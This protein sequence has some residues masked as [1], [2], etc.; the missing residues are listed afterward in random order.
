MLL[1]WVP[2]PPLQLIVC[3]QP[4]YVVLLSV[5]SAKVLG[6]LQNVYLFRVKASC[7]CLKKN[8]Q[9]TIIAITL[10]YMCPNL[11]YI[12]LMLCGYGLVLC[13]HVGLLSGLLSSAL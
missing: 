10:K 12:I 9:G 2:P 13:V 5:L 11:N 8:M 1:C 3:A 6:G 7:M 4:Q